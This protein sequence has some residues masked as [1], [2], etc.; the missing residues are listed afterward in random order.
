MRKAKVFTDVDLERNRTL[1]WHSIAPGVGAT[2]APLCLGGGLFWD[3]SSRTARG[4][5]HPHSHPAE[6]AMEGA[7][8]ASPGTGSQGRGGDGGGRAEEERQAA[9]GIAGPPR[10]LCP[11]EG[12]RAPYKRGGAVPL[13]LPGCP[14]PAVPFLPGP[15]ERRSAAWRPPGASGGGSAAR[16]A[17]GLVGMDV[18]GGRGR[19]R[20]GPGP[21][22]GLRR[23]WPRYG[24]SR[25]RGGLQA[26]TAQPHGSRRPVRGGGGGSGGEGCGGSGAAPPAR[27]RGGERGLRLVRRC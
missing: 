22:R 2:C 26:G 27:P 13:V 25:C 6:P 17:R 12:K 10:C 14:P 16:R 19:A 8:G 9:G 20:A 24:R 18:C 21:G 4:A 5:H 3:S 23:G 1:P 7:P 11:L 15:G